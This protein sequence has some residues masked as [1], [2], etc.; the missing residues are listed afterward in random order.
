[1]HLY[2][3]NAPVIRADSLKAAAEN[4]ADVGIFLYEYKLY[5]SIHANVDIP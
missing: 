5:H 1:M 4:D 2:V 3:Q